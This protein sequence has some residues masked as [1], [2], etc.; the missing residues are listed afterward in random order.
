LGRDG[1]GNPRAGCEGRRGPAR[2]AQRC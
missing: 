2:E 1:N